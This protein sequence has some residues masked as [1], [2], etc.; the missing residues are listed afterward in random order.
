ME[1]QPP[2]TLTSFP[3]EQEFD[4]TASSLDGADSGAFNKLLQKVKSTFIANAS[5]TA[6]ASV[7][8]L[9]ESQ[10]E[11]HGPV[12]RA[13]ELE[14]PPVDNPRP[15]PPLP[16]PRPKLKALPKKTATDSLLSLVNPHISRQRLLHRSAPSVHLH[17]PDDVS[18]PSAQP[19]QV[20]SAPVFSSSTSELNY[21]P[22]ISGGEGQAV[23]AIPGFPI[24]DNEDTRSLS[25]FRGGPGVSH[26][27]RRLRGE[28]GE[29]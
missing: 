16:P 6:T 25:S 19:L 28:V 24:R 17:S 20:Y 4:Q 12:T 10:D 8:H 7:S 26:I 9:E 23:G 29:L 15:A 14:G 18:P 13:P 11:D 3:F 22:S 1:S 5:S 2:E 21:A 27:F